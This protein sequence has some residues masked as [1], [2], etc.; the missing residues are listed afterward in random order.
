MPV[1]NGIGEAIHARKSVIR[2]IVD[3]AGDDLRLAVRGYADGGN[4]EITTQMQLVH[5]Q[6]RI[7]VNI[8]VVLEYIHR[9]LV[10]VVG[11]CG[12]IL[13]LDSIV[14]LHD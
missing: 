11:L 2:R 4:A 5:V 8:P 14:H 3:L 7:R 9:D 10:L 1:C 6:R 13:R 12:V